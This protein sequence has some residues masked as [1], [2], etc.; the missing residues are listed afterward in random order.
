LTVATAERKSEM[1][2]HSN[3]SILFPHSKKVPFEEGLRRANEQNLILASNKRLSIALTVE[4]T[5]DLMGQVSGC[6]TGTMAGY[7]KPGKEFDKTIEYVDEKS[8]LKWVFPVPEQFRGEKNAVLVAEHPG[9]ILET[10]GNNRVI[11]ATHVD[12]VRNFPGQTVYRSCGHSVG[13]WFEGDP[14][15]D[16]PQGRDISSDHREARY[17]T[18]IEKRVGPVKREYSCDFEFMRM[19]CLSEKPSDGFGIIVEQ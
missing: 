15:H 1:S 3:L 11:H 16:I 9:Y 18:R 8:G 2:K 6:W 19:V 4:R 14:E 5:W 17:L 10:D 13:A 7:E 12:L